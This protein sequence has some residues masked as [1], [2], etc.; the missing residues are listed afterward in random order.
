MEN[1]I[2]GQLGTL[3]NLVTAKLKEEE[4]SQTDQTE[5]W[6]ASTAALLVDHLIAEDPVPKGHCKCCHQPIPNWEDTAPGSPERY[7][8]KH[9]GKMPNGWPCPL[10]FMHH[11]VSLQRSQIE[12]RAKS[13]VASHRT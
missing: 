12:I 13:N 4:E 5:Y 3:Q 11:L 10:P 9:H 1:S 2:Y 8:K 7:L 6:L